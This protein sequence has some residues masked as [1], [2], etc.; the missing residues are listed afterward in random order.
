MVPRCLQL[1]RAAT[2]PLEMHAVSVEHTRVCPKNTTLFVIASSVVLQ[3]YLFSGR[4]VSVAIVRCT[5]PS[6][7]G[8]LR[9]RTEVCQFVRSNELA[10]VTTIDNTNP[11]LDKGIA[12][13][14]EQGLNLFATLDCNTLPEAVSEPMS[15]SIDLGSYSRLVVLGNTGS[16]FWHALQ[17]AG[18]PSSDPMDNFSK[19]VTERFLKTVLA[20]A[21]NELVFPTH[22]IVPLQ[23]IGALIGWG[24]VSPLGVGISEKHGLWFAYRSAFVTSAELPVSDM[25]QQNM[26]CRDCEDK[27]CISACPA[28]AV[29]TSATFDVDGCFRFRAAKNSP[30]IDRCRS[31][32]A[33]PVGAESRYPREMITY[34]YNTSMK[35]VRRYVSESGE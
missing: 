28:S 14:A 12:E 11:V 24:E 29:D 19:S 8:G 6:S 35:T 22:H 21:R 16:R 32:E 5:G 23:R 13:L 4:Q 9:S 17:S 18:M 20:D 27:P 7:V 30:C 25:P 2:G 3:R 31:R 10:G 33:C 34:I 15:A 26:P 1:T